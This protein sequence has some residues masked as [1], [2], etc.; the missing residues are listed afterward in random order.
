[1]NKLIDDLA[2]A[3]NPARWQAARRLLFTS[4]KV[5]TGIETPADESIVEQ[6]L[7]S[8]SRDDGSIRHSTIGRNSKGDAIPVVK[9]MPRQFK[10]RLTILAHPRGKAAIAGGRGRPNELASAL[11]ARGH[12]VVAFDPVFVGESL[13][14]KNPVDH[15]PD[16]AH[17]ETYN[18]SRA[19]DQMQDLATVIAW[20]KGQPDVDLVN[21]VAQN[22]AGYQALV[23]RPML[24]GLSRTVIE[25]AGMPQTRKPDEW[26]ASIDLAGLEQF[27]GVKAAAALSA[28]SPLW[29]YGDLSAIDSKWPQA[30]YDLA[31][32]AQMFRLEQDV[33]PPEQIARWVDEGQ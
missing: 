24:E 13:D 1:V 30:A 21:L 7:R 10:N 29:L 22:D 17:F 4:L 3:S 33:P 31:G 23:A 11:L 16:V 25:L 19:A 12:A 15:R 18:P 28:P 2:P 26:P 27:G 9:L 8:I 20:A 14:P 5:R 32:A 6:E